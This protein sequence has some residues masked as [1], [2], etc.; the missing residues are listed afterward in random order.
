MPESI[1]IIFAD[2]EASRIMLQRVRLMARF[3]SDRHMAEFEA[4][5]REQNV[6]KAE[7][8]ETV[9][10]WAHNDLSNTLVLGRAT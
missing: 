3:I 7:P 10:Y 1:A 5:W 6:S 9:N 2:T 4:Y 8:S